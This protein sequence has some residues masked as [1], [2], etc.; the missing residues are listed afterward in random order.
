MQSPA[1][2]RRPRRHHR[3]TEAT[4][5]IS[6]IRARAERI[7]QSGQARLEQERERRYV[8]A[9]GFVILDRSRHT[10]ASVLA[11]ALAFR[12]FLTLLPL[13]LVSVVGLGVLRDIG[14]SPS[15]AVKQFGIKGVL[16]STINSSANF[17]DPGRTAVLLLGVVGVFGGARTT[18][19]TIRAIHALAWGIPI[20]RWRKGGRAGLLFLGVV[21]VGFAFGGL[22][23]RAR[24][25]AGVVLG[26][27]ASATIGAA[28]AAIWFGVSFLLP[29][30]EGVRWTAFVPGA[31][32]VG[33]GFAILQAVTANWIGPK[34]N[35][36]SSLYGSLGVSFAVLGW[37]YVVGR[38]IVA[39]PLLNSSIVA[40]HAAKGEGSAEP[41]SPAETAQASVAT[42]PQAPR[43]PPARE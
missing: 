21:I 34:L 32:L 38:L 18:A 30:R 8:V 3:P 43:T 12:F 6:D 5:R 9:L 31:V 35:K 29:H 17:S 11:G 37:L 20:R 14:G 1:A 41:E 28:V 24:A 36:E 15:D 23:T 13:T 16:A 26:F 42:R 33:A 40:H 10:A 22:A 4:S 25:E 2:R 39:A 7:A 19:A 27:G